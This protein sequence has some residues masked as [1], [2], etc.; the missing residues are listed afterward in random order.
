MYILYFVYI[1]YTENLQVFSEPKKRD[2]P[3]RAVISK[4]GGATAPIALARLS[5]PDTPLV[6]CCLRV[7]SNG[8]FR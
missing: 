3:T 7:H 6:A 2:P 5:G 8:S 1:K 4:R